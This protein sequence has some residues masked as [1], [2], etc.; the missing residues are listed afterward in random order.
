MHDATTARASGAP[1]FLLMSSSGGD[2]QILQ[3]VAYINQFFVCLMISLGRDQRGTQPARKRLGRMMP[4]ASRTLVVRAR[5]LTS[6]AQNQGKG[7]LHRLPW[8]NNA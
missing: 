6:S 2:L 8:L 3:N 4:A 7:C 1:K 5:Q